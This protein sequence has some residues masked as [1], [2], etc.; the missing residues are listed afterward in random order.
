M[1]AYLAKLWQE[2]LEGATFL[3]ECLIELVPYAFGTALF[4]TWLGGFV[5]LVMMYNA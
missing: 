4:V 2:E 3:R 5:G 1:K